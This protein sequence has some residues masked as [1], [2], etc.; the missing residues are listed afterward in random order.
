MLIA[1]TPILEGKKIKEYKGAIFAQVARGT[2]FGRNFA[3]SLRSTFGGRSESHETLVIETRE[4]AMQELIE[5]AKKLGANA[6]IGL[7]AD[8]EMISA[9]T[10]LLFKA[11]ATAV[12]IE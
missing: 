8:Y 2:G 1:T 11:S 4:A 5:E 3:A 9:D 6:I 7:N 12:V 10:L